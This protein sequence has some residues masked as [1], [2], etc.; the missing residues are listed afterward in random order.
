[1]K[2]DYQR[3]L[4]ILKEANSVVG[5]ELENLLDQLWIGQDACNRIIVIVRHVDLPNY[6]NRFTFFFSYILVLLV[7]CF[8]SVPHSR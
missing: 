1:M 6:E 8:V 3:V 7:V 5:D 4:S 2:A